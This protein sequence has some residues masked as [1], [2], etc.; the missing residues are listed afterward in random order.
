MINSCYLITLVFKT[1]I[2]MR[3]IK[4]RETLQQHEAALAELAEDTLP[5]YTIL[6]PLYREVE[7]L[8]QMINAM[9][10]MDYPRSK[11]DIKIV[12]EA[13]DTAT[14]E[15]AKA[16]QPEG[17]FEMI[18]VP[19][20][21]PRTKPKACN[22]ALRFAR[23]EYVTIYDA[24]DLPDPQQLKR[25]VRRFR[26]AP[27]DT[28]C[29]QCRLNYYNRDRNLL[30]KLFAIEY[31]AWFDY[32]LVGLE[33]LKLPIPLGG[34]SNH[35]ARQRLLELGEWDPYNV[36]EDADLGIRMAVA[37]YR[38]LTLDSLTLEE[39]PVGIW[40]WIKQRSRWVKGYLQTWLVH[41]RSPFR[42]YQ[43]LGARGFW[44]FQLFIGG[45]CF[46][47]LSTPILLT[48]SLLWHFGLFDLKH[49]YLPLAMVTSLLVFGY[50]LVMHLAFALRVLRDTGWKQMHSALLMFPFYWLLHSLASFRGLY[51]LITRPHYW[52]KTTHGV[53]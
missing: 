4:V 6:I 19:P 43:Q 51:Q 14:I 53:K 31:A 49:P 25:V 20:S 10:Q 23:G 26:N 44:G 17:C 52:D 1:L 35:I 8:P 48:I 16:M 15:A 37:K 32:M 45:P 29:V 41:M 34:T 40:A 11:L 39:A 7:V 42:L 13:D 28:V 22:Y 47:F 12:M 27:A 18:L 38:T 24:E 5:I 30:T 2:F 46:V 33:A 3:G 9:R 21:E 36:T 50:G